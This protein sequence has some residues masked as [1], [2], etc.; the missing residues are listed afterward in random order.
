[1]YT[2]QSVISFIIT[3]IVRSG[4]QFRGTVYYYPQTK[5]MNIASFGPIAPR[6]PTNNLNDYAIIS[7]GNDAAIGILKAQAGTSEESKLTANVNPT[8]LQKPTNATTDTTG[9]PV[10]RSSLTARR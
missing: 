5:Q 7:N 4:S 10:A 8:L 1:M 6:A 9:T 3:Y 2:S